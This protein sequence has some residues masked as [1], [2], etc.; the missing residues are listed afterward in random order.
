MSNSLPKANAQTKELLIRI[1][2]AAVLIPIVLLLTFWGDFQL[3]GASPPWLKT[4]PWLSNQRPMA[5]VALLIAV[6]ILLAR[7]WGRMTETKHEHSVAVG[8]TF[9]ALFATIVS[10]T[11]HSAYALLAL[12]GSSALLAGYTKWVGAHALNAVN[13]ALY[14][15]TPALTLMWLRDG[16]NGVYWVLFA[17]CIAWASD[18]AAYFSGKWF[19]GPKLWPSFSPNKTWAGFVGGLI[20]GILMAIVLDD[21]THLFKHGT[22][23]FFV[24]LVT[25]LAVMAGDLWES[26]M[27]RRF[28]VKDAGALI[29]GHGGLLDRVDGLMF[30]ILAVG[31]IRL[32]TLLGTEI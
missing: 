31:L 2:S 4:H 16:H 1:A 6:V 11:Q 26:A 19:K 17:L 5:F 7:E 24:G 30:A 28:G 15:G 10:Y 21:M 13:G 3:L 29:P 27:K 32:L 22:S 25:A 14:I 18:S 20:A 9:V 8:V 23:A 12:I